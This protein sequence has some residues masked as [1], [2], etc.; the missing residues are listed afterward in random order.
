MASRLEALKLGVLHGPNLNLLGLRQ[1]GI[2]GDVPLARVDAGLRGLGKDLG[3]ELDIF[4]ANGEGELIDWIHSSA[5]GVAG[6]LVNAG[7]YTTTS[8]A[9]LDALLGVGRPFVEVHL[10]NVY[11]RERFRQTSLLAPHAVGLVVGFGEDSY[12]LGLRGLVSHLRSEGE[13]NGTG[14]TE[15]GQ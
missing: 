6:F 8:V 4:Q 2:Y 14:K 10:S 11:G 1:P 7:G 13:N 12:R 15:E 9:L 5:A 3:V